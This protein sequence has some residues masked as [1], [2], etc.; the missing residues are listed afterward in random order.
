[1]L[2]PGSFIG[3]T[4]LQIKNHIGSGSFGDVYAVED[5]VL[6]RLFVVKME[7]LNCSLPSLKKEARLLKH[8]NVS[9][10]PGVPWLYSYNKT[11]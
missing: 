3:E 7:L 10:N 9:R 4:N 2:Q 5:V 11:D 1:M 8:L 6:K